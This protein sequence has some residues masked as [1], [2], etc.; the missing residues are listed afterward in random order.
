[1]CSSRSI[2]GDNR[3]Q[4]GHSG[5]QG[6]IVDIAGSAS[7]A[8]LSRW[9]QQHGSDG[10][11]RIADAGWGTHHK[12]V[13]GGVQFTHADRESYLG[14]TIIHFGVNIFNTLCRFSGLGGQTHPP[15][16]HWGGSLLNCSFYLD[17]EL[18]VDHGRLVYNM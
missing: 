17:D 16:I 5:K 18:V 12:A 14:C 2:P 10:A 1:M 7:A 8:V 4:N 9:L 3:R 11:H 6:K 13:W 15:I